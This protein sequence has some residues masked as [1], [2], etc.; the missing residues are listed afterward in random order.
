MPKLTRL[1][2]LSSTL[3]AFFC[4]CFALS[5]TA[6]ASQV[7]PVNLHVVEPRFIAQGYIS[8]GNIQSTRINYAQS[9]VP[10][11]V[12]RIYFSQGQAVKK[13]DVLM[14]LRAQQ[15]GYHLNAAKAQLDKA[16]A[17]YTLQQETVD[18]L[19]ALYHS[20]A[21][22]KSTLQ[23]EQV[24]LLALKSDREMAQAQYNEAKA[25]LGDTNIRSPLTGYLQELKVHEGTVV[26][27]GT[28]L[29]LV[30]DTHHL[31]AVLPYSQDFRNQIKPG[32]TVE[33][34]ST[35]NENLPLIKTK[36]AGITPLIS[37]FNRTF[38]VLVYFDNPG[39]WYPGMSVKGKVIINPHKKVFLVPPS[40]V[41]LT[42]KGPAVFVVKEGRAYP[43][44][45][46]M[47]DGSIN[48]FDVLLSGVKSGDKVVTD[49]AGF[50][51]SGVRVH[52]MEKQ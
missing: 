49:G 4:L 40:S 7:V 46:T 16:N 30:A 27:A 28:L 48:G 47:E 9:T 13:G 39:G 24:R 29:A 41:V 2:F 32:Q 20:G 3:P 22:T 33:L 8:I 1:R 42:L 37:E 38:G 44:P 23:A 11:R 51:H 35:N 15:E 45:I 43:L 31:K 50:L 14:T 10:G 34:Y 36:V 17:G 21:I 12:S 18:R 19:T 5:S 6:L 52:V 25:R 26:A